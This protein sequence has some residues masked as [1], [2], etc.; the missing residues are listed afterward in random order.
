[1]PKKDD[2]EHPAHVLEVMNGEARPTL[3]APENYPGAW[4]T[5]QIEGIYISRISC[6]R[7]PA[8]LSQKLQSLTFDISCIPLPPDRLHFVADILVP[9][10]KFIG[11]VTVHCTARFRNLSGDL[12]S[13]KTVNRYGRRY[14]EWVA[15]SLWDTGAA[16]LRSTIA[17]LPMADVT[18]PIKTPEPTF[19][20]IRRIRH[21][22][23]DK[24]TS[25]KAN[26]P[27]S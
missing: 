14:V 4:P 17:L 24:S 21:N 5:A 19:R 16:A 10:D 20:S 12:D 11:A 9:G 7:K 15:H 13:E 1:M 8:S 22:G 2:T 6:T 23:T 27:N 3:E 25:S 26:D 18:V